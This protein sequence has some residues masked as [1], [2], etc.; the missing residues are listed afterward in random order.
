MNFTS[1]HLELLGVVIVIVVAVSW[2]SALSIHSN[3]NVGAGASTF[4]E[5]LFD[6]VVAPSLSVATA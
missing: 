5:I 4:T 6:F 1:N 2:I 3:E